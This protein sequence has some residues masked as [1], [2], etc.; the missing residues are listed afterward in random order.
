MPREN[1]TS[2]KSTCR[3]IDFLIDRANIDQATQDIRSSEH[4]SIEL[5][6]AISNLLKKSSDIDTILVRF[7]N[8]TQ[9][10]RL[11]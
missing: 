10:V 1:R 8:Q 6:Q 11:K 2:L 7:K 3:S 4:Q 5:D 9:V